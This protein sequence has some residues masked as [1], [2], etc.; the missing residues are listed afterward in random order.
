MA[1]ALVIARKHS[2]RSDAL[3]SPHK[4]SV[5]FNNPDELCL[6]KVDYAYGPVQRVKRVHSDRSPRAM[7][8]R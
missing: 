6:V 5:L 3:M 1:P 8:G 2:L 7:A 4:V